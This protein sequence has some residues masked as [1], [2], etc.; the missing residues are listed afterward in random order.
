[1]LLVKTK[2]GPSKIHGIGLFADQFIPQGM[3]VWEF[4]EGFDMEY[5]A[6]DLERLSEPARAQFLHY[7][8]IDPDTRRYVLCADDARF[9][10]HSET[11]TTIN[12]D[13]ADPDIASRD[14][15]PGEELTYDYRTGDMDYTRK[16]G[17]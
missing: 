9:S 13:P 16:L 12:P 17:L 15:Q 7:C 5:T 1:M 2:I 3:P 10:N 8:Y 11:P 6:E 4:T 14:I